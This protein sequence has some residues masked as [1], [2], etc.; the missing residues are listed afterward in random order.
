MLR[1]LLGNLLLFF[2]LGPIDYKL[3]VIELLNLANENRYQHDAA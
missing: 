1:F 2:L 3:F